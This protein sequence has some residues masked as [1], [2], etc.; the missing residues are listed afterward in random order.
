MIYPSQSTIS[1]QIEAVVDGT[2]CFGH[3]KVRSLVPKIWR[4]GCHPDGDGAGDDRDGVK[5]CLSVY[6]LVVV[7]II[8]NITTA[9]TP[10]MIFILRTVSITNSDHG[11]K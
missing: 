1:I 2:T 11:M 8:T 4:T 3:P 10:T 5:R 9:N 7:E 6:W